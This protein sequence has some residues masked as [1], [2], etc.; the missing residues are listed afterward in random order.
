VK[1][2]TGVDIVSLS[3]F[4]QS[5][6]N[7]G[8]LFLDRCFHKIEQ[9][10]TDIRHMAGVYA[11]KEAVIKAL[12]MESGSWLDIRVVHEGNGRPKAELM[13]GKNDIESLDISIS[14]DGEYAVA[15]C[16]AVLNN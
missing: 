15:S 10:K 12:S 2:R 4:T 16:C 13:E 9:D 3:S 6:E 7:G 1:I 11:A 14:H 8:Q 5:L